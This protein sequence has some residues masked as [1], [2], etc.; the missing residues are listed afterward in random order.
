M[1]PLKKATIRHLSIALLVPSIAGMIWAG[2][3]RANYLDTLPKRPVFE[4]MRVVPRNIGGT[5]VYQTEE[6]SALITR[7]DIASGAI[8]L[9]GAFLGIVY[10]RR[11]GMRRML[12]NDEDQ[13]LVEEQ[14]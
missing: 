13:A 14:R 2:T 5:V 6:E 12:E 11:W 8:F 10:L 3:I 9:V 4:Q 7:I 1:A